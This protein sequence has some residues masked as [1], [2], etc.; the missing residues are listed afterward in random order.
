MK[1]I[2][3]ILFISTICV[4]AFALGAFNLFNGRNHPELI[5]K[6]INTENCKIVYHEPLL[7]YAQQSADIAQES[8]ITYTK[9]YG[10]VPE[11]KMIIYLS[12]QD[13][14][15]NGAAVLTYYIMIWVNQNDFTKSFTGNDKWLRKVI[16]HEASHWFVAQSLKD[17]MSPFLPLGALTFP[18]SLNEGF[19]QFFSG[20]PWGYNRGDRFLRRSIYS[21]SQKDP[22]GMFEGGL[23]YGAGFSMV[24]YLQIEYGEEKLMQMLQYRNQAKMYNFDKAF[25]KV[26]EKSFEEF[27]EEWR[28]YVYTYYYGQAFVQQGT[29]LNRDFSIN[30]LTE[31]KSN[32]RDFQNIILKEDKALFM[33]RK[34]QT[35]RYYDL[36]LATVN[37]D[38]LKKNNFHFKDETYIAKSGNFPSFSISENN[39]WVAYSTYTRADKGK[40]APRVYLYS[41]LEKKKFT[42]SEGNLVQVDNAGGVYFQRLDRDSNKIYYRCPLGGETIWLELDKSIQVGDLRLSPSSDLLAITTFDEQNKFSISVYETVNSKLIMQQELP[43]MVQ[44]L[45]WQD[46]QQIIISMEKAENYQLAIYKLQ[47]AS[48]SLSEYQTPPFNIMP[49]KVETVND[50]TFTYAL[51]EYYRGGFTLGKTMLNEKEIEEKPVAQ[52]YYTKWID[53]IPNNPLTDPIPSAEKS[54]PIAYNSF[55]NIKWRQGFVLPL[56]KQALGTFILSE[57]LGKHMISGSG[58][59]PYDLSDKKYWV[60]MYNNNCFYPSIFVMALETEWFAG[61]EDKKMYFQDMLNYSISADFPINTSTFFSAMNVGLGLHYHDI[62]KNKSDFLTY[63]DDA[64]VFSTEGY[65]SYVYNL[66]WRN[67]YYHPVRKIETR[68]SLQNGFGDYQYTQNSLQLNASYA[69]FLTKFK[70]EQLK[71]ISLISNNNIQHVSGDQL[72]QFMP[73]IDQYEFFQAGTQP[74]FNR[75]YLRGYEESHTAKTLFNSQN[76]LT[77]KISDAFIFGGYAGASLFVDYTRLLNI[78]NTQKD[79][80]YR[81]AGAEIKAAVN[82]FGIDVLGKYGIAFNFKG[83]EL[84]EYFIISLPFGANM[85]N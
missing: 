19:A 27:T 50:T 77:V 75:F 39:E 13:N 32:W 84:N 68:Y 47:V 42:L 78:D 20:E 18:T 56:Y 48:K 55:K 14:I 16:A 1:K 23:M 12:D 29:D 15:S 26:Y 38:S 53:T 59:I 49:L 2:I 73:G 80:E 45:F 61:I 17:W 71:T 43:Y 52:N 4:Q 36:V 44:D 63:F 76:E 28:R 66:P 3:F 11:D 6:E 65:A 54:E 37:A 79:K 64:K 34:S 67:S 62:K 70:E 24:R 60:L 83:E 22:S 41:V 31:Y 30:A 5:W 8:F 35:Q 10:I 74:A 85:L 25:K 51:T 82:L 69:P 72:K 7:E 21:Q 58:L 46:D 33:A 81:A 9:T 40:I 57:P